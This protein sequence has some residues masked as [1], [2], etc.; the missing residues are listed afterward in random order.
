MDCHCLYML[1]KTYKYS[2]V[3]MVIPLAQNKFDVDSRAVPDSY[4]DF[5]DYLACSWL[6]SLKHSIG[7]AFVG[8]RIFGATAIG[9]CPHGHGHCNH[10]RWCS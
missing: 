2:A 9:G 3:I 5:Q 8:T 6:W 10:S 1:T 4:L 7:L